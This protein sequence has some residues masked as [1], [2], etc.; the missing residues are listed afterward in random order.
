MNILVVK[1]NKF[2]LSVH[3]EQVH[4]VLDIPVKKFVEGDYDSLFNADKRHEEAGD[5][6]VGI[7]AQQNQHQFDPRPLRRP[8]FSKLLTAEEVENARRRNI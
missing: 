4:P 6:P 5:V 8:F 2:K 3:S 7:L 1:D